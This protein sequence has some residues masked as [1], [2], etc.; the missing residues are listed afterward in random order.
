MAIRFDFETELA[1]VRRRVQR[2]QAAIDGSAQVT[3]VEVKEHSV[4]AHKRAAHTRYVITL[5]KKS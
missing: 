3:E 2:L 4:R 5:G 1:T